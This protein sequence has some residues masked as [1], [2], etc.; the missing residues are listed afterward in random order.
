MQQTEEVA[1]TES[2]LA[3]I[4]CDTTGVVLWRERKGLRARLRLHSSLG[5]GDAA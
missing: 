3:F 1:A 5:C 2:V 4:P